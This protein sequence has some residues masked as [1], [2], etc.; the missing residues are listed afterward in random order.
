MADNLT[1]HTSAALVLR[2]A[3]LCGVAAESLGLKG[4]SGV[5]KSVT[6][7]KAFLT[8]TGYRG[9]GSCMCPNIRRG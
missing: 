3:S 9:C 8:N 6:T 7:R 2:V 1:T 4:K 5:L